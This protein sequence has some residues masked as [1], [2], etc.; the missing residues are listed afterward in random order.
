MICRPTRPKI[1]VTLM[2]VHN[3]NISNNELK[4]KPICSRSE[5]S[6]CYHYSTMKTAKDVARQTRKFYLQANLLLRNFRHCSEDVKC[7]FFRHTVLISI[8]VICGLI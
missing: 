5:I 1:M 3:I 6:W 7:V 4:F 8:V 2:F